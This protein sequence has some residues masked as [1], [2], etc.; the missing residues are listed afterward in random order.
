MEQ[1]V[2][3]TENPPATGPL[4]WLAIAGFVVILVWNLVR[5]WRTQGCMGRFVMVAVIGLFALFILT[6]RSNKPE[7]PLPPTKVVLRP[8]GITVQY[9]KSTPVTLLRGQVQT[10]NRQAG[11]DNSKI[12]MRPAK[13]PGASIIVGNQQVAELCGQIAASLGLRTYDGGYTWS[14]RD[15][16][17]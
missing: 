7:E 11:D 13:G 3:V 9:P 1:V 2:T 14:Y 10:M 8:D 12:I 16:N 17:P 5:T 4:V 6:S 15:P